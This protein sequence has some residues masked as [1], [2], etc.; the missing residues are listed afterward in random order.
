MSQPNRGGG[1]KPSPKVEEFP[2]A[3]GSNDEIKAD[4]IIEPGEV[5]TID[6]KGNVTIETRKVN[7]IKVEVVRPGYIKGR[8]VP[9][10]ILLIP[11]DEFA[12]TWMKKLEE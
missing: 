12:E 4:F 3:P 6:K 1:Q 8:H 7:M 11:E 2:K 10:D 5:E 9:G